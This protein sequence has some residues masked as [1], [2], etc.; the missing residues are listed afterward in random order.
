VHFLQDNCAEALQCYDRAIELN[1]D[2]KEF[3]HNRAL[4]LRRMG[5]CG[6]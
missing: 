1:G 4:V 2:I 6:C 3:F 5:R